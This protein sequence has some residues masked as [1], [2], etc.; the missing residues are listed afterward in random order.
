MDARKMRNIPYIEEIN[1]YTDGGCKP[2]PGDGA[3]AVLLCSYDD[4]LLYEY[5]ERIGYCTNNQAEYRAAIRGLELSA[6]YTRGRVICTSDSEL[7]VKQMN[8]EYRLKDDKLR[9]LFYEVNKV[10]APFKEVH[11][12]HSHRQNQR[13]QRADRLAS[14]AHEGRCTKKCIVEP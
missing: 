3:I 9:E 5:S 1:V 11:F 7:F 14:E 6:K 8:G 4:K 12:V 13:I 10:C 2:N